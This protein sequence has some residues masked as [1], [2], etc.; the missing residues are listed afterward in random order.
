M[1]KKKLIEP[2]DSVL[3]LYMIIFWVCQQKME[4]MDNGLPEAFNS[5]EY[6]A[7]QQKQETALDSYN[8]LYDEL[9]A[10]LNTP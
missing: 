7:L 5:K 2:D 3:D 8:E 1:K 6:N 9:K 10:K 4:A